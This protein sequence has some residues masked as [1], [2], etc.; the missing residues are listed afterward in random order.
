MTALAPMQ[1]VQLRFTPD[2]SISEIQQWCRPNWRL[3]P[4]GQ[5]DLGL[6]LHRAFDAAFASGSR[7]VAVIGSD[8]P[9]VT[10]PDIITAWQAL[11]T[12]DLVLGPARDG[13]YWLIALRQPQPELFT[14][15]PWSSPSVL[16][17]TLSAA[18]SANLNTFLLRE[19]SDID[20]ERDWL[21]FLAKRTTSS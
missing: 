13:G 5:G 1:H 2:D 18:T 6:R 21:D 7:R 20:L 16:Q 4:Q 19:L 3:Q 14:G 9:L 8:C 12:H 17:S 11:D 10:P 15:I